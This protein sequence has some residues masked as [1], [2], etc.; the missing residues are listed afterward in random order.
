MSSKYKITDQQSLHFITFATVQWVDALSR[1]LYKDITIES[2]KYCQSEKGLNL[3]AYVIMNNHIH[4][5]T[6]AKEGYNLSDILRDF[7]KFTSKKTLSAIENNLQESRRDW[8][9]W[10]FRSAGK[11]NSNNTNYQFWQQD[12]RPIELS[13]NEMMEQRLNYIH[14]N[15]VKERIVEEPEHYIYSSAKTYT[16]EVGLIEVLLIE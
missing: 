3:Y 11:K 14:M 1:P 7:K 4:L 15:P 8:M 13:V 9:L 12:N 6:S 10:L 5:I 16:G 2:L